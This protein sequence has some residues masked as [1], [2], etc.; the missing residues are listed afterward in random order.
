M[1]A[2]VPFD[3]GTFLQQGN[4][5]AVPMFSDLAPPALTP[6][7]QTSHAPASAHMQAQTAAAM[8]SAHQLDSTAQ[9]VQ[10]TISSLLGH[11]V[12]PSAPLMAAG[13][14]SL[15]A[16]ELRN[17]LQSRFAL[18]LPS[19]LVFDYPTV[20]DIATFIASQAA[21]QPSASPVPALQ[22]QAQ[23]AQQPPPTA[24]AVP[25]QQQ[26]PCHVGGTV[27]QVVSNI[28]GKTIP[29]NVPLMTAG[30]DSLAMVEVRNALQTSLNLQLPSTLL[31]DYPTTAA[32]TDYIQAQLPSASTFQ[33]QQQA[34]AMVQP[35][36]SL[37]PVQQQAP[38]NN[39]AAITA[40]VMHMPDGALTNAEAIDTSRLIPLDR[41][42]MDTPPGGLFTGA[43]VS[44]GSYLSS[45][46]A[47]D[48]AAFG[49]SDT[50]AMYMDPQQRLLLHTT[51]EA[52]A[53]AQLQ[54]RGHS[55]TAVFV[56]VSS[57]DYDK[58]V[59]LHSRGVTAYTATGAA[60]SVTSGRLSYT[61]GLKGPSVA[62]DTA[63]SSSLVS[64]HMAYNSLVL[65]QCDAAV[66]S[67]VNV[68]LS[69]YTQAAFQKA[70]MLAANGR[71]KVMDSSADGYVADSLSA[72]IK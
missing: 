34:T 41:W 7:L 69:P 70:G 26:Q 31:F 28:L 18:Q 23:P 17:A 30:L 12:D 51:A 13:L 52:L 21:T 42:D 22:K 11:A 32:I 54:S 44:F 65:Q 35:M 55:S 53:V 43:A 36:H 16:V 37:G 1:V 38:T 24:V 40:L 9:T 49:T 58:L 39:V 8:P 63:C 19:T 62:V 46:A 6:A 61:F 72:C 59:R 68:M 64:L 10:A 56:G 50:E 71:C 2:A 48:A 27:S 15:G 14:D 3:W 45:P 66:N 60:A 57:S 67:G 33:Q 20:D 5:R 47:F 29:E 4:N 25:D